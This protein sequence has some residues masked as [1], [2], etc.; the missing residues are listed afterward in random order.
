MIQQTPEMTSNPRRR[1]D[2]HVER[3]DDE[4]CIYDE[5]TQRAHV[6]NE[7][8]ARVWESCDGR[9]GVGELATAL[10]RE[11][12]GLTPAAAEGVVAE[13]LARLREVGL[14]LE[15]GD[16]AVAGSGLT[17]RALLGLGVGAAAIPV[18]QTRRVPGALAQ[19]SEPR[20]LRAYITNFNG[21]NVSVIDTA[22]NTVIATITV[23]DQPVGVAVNP[24]GTLVYVANFSSN[25]V[26]VIDAATNTVTATVT[27]GTNPAA[28]GDFVG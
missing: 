28:F 11:T 8:A 5:A 1:D 17:R 15:E 21:D 14:L 25:T 7:T 24:A 3:L 4:L 13:A 12:E 16:V 20:A 9:R 22:T 27:V 2:L 23:G 26:S 10:A 6:L 19:S 18:V